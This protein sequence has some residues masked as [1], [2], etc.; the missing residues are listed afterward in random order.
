MDIFQIG[1]LVKI[2]GKYDLTIFSPERI[3]KLD[4]HFFDIRKTIAMLKKIG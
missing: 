2:D 3:D 4:E 1:Q